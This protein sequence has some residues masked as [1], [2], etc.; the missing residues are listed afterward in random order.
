[1]VSCVCITLPTRSQESGLR[2]ILVSLKFYNILLNGKLKKCLVRSDVMLPQ[3]QRHK[4]PNDCYK[5][6]IKANP[7][8]KND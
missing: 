8:E 3:K 5:N 7:K 6:V 1:M 2:K 4:K